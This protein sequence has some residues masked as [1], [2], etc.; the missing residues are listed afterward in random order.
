MILKGEQVSSNPASSAEVDHKSERGGGGRKKREDEGGK[1]SR[2]Q[3]GEG[4][5]RM[6]L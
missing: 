4:K 5:G 1:S 2:K 3:G 6:H